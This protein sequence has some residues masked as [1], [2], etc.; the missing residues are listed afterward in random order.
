MEN[1]NEW[2]TVFSQ[3]LPHYVD[4][5][6]GHRV[7]RITY[8]YHKPTKTI[9]YIGK[10]CVRKYNIQFSLTNPILLEVIK[11]NI[12]RSEWDKDTY[13]RQ[14]IQWQYKSFMTTSSNPSLLRT[15]LSDIYDLISEYGFDLVDISNTIERD[16]IRLDYKT[17]TDD[18]SHSVLMDEYSYQSISDIESEY[19]EED[20][21][22][23]HIEGLH[24]EKIINEIVE[25]IENMVDSETKN[26]INKGE[27]ISKP[28]IIPL[29]EIRVPSCYCSF[30]FCYCEMK[31]RMRRMQE[32]MVDLNIRIQNTR[33][34]TQALLEKTQTLLEKT[35]TYRRS[36]QS[37]VYT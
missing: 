23:T 36:I 15:L 20:I 28:I 10:T 8:L 22:E 14:H 31:Y 37:I 18:I 21:E 26:D 6:C 19:S 30:S 34:E 3:S 12:H 11:D 13:V 27:L 17:Q 16:I 25:K 7:K 29:N 2:L 32:D 35:Q 9:Q 33:D 4:C 1:P 5:I 24:I